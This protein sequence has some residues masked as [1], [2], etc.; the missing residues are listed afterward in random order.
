MRHRDALF[1]DQVDIALD[2]LGEQ[3]QRL[4]AAGR[5]AGVQREVRAFQRRGEAVGLVG[6]AALCGLLRR[7]AARVQIASAR[8]AHPDDAH[9]PAQRNEPDAVFGLAVAALDDRGREADV[10]LGHAHAHGLG[11]DE[12]PE[13]VDEDEGEQ[14]ADGDQAAQPGTPA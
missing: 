13:L 5:V 11:D 12:V 10:E 1:V 6:R 2:R 3:L 8:A 7:L 4:G 14:A 9:E